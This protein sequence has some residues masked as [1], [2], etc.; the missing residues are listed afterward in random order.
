M[1]IL[2]VYPEVPDTFWGFRHILKFSKVR[3]TQP[4]LGLLTV[5]AM[6][7]QEWDKKLVDIN[8]SKLKDEDL[9]WADYVFI[10]AM[11]IQRKSVEEVIDRCMLAGVKI[12]AGG[13]LF[14]TESERYMECDHLVL[15]EAEIT[16]PQFL[17]DLE[18]GT[19][20]HV[21]T[22]DE[23]VDMAETP[24]PLWSIVEMDRYVLMNIQYSRGCPFDCEFC[25][26]PVLYGE[27]VRTKSAD[28][29]ISEL[30][31][32]YANGWRGSVFFVD[33]NLIGNK[34]QLKKE[35]LPAI[36]EWQERRGRPFAFQTETS[37]NLADDQK[38]MDLMVE[39]GFNSVF[40]GIETPNEESLAECNKVQNK[41]RDM[42]ESIKLIQSSGMLVSA[43]F[44]IGFDNDTPTIFERMTDFISQSGV[45]SAMVGL[46]NA[47]MHS[48]LH[49]RMQKE[50]RMID[51]IHS[52][53][54]DYTMNFKPKM[55]LDT[56]LKGYKGVIR[57]IYSLGPYYERI[58]KFMNNYRTKTVIRY[59]LKWWHIVAIFKSFF[60]LG[61][62]EKGKSHFWK[63]FF[64]T[65]TRHPRLFPMAMTLAIYG[66]HYRKFY[67][68]V[69]S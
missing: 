41:N 65:L 59:H 37:I 24:A 26:I 35:I 4:P 43:G 21:Y 53:H 11:A 18:K 12:V 32:I 50:G 46:L 5:A 69:L 7:P 8:V 20:R 47:P 61:F 54:M 39:A 57:D 30:E 68:S 60:V 28:Q 44:I 1:K 51:G 23:F 13:P 29:I 58:R 14:S 31:L 27:R 48:R 15:N 49:V 42:L 33:D 3:A 25:S 2:L 56:L 22:S 10:S 66:L 36:I 38:L 52:D 67:H 6:L 9:E 62:R 64:W 17:A 63:L 40:I 55:D 16:L 19:P 45:V 34:K